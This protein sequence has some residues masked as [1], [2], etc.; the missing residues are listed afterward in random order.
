[1]LRG[2]LVNTNGKLDD[3]GPLLGR[4]VPHVWRKI[5]MNTTNL[6]QRREDAKIMKSL[7]LRTASFDAAY[8]IID[9]VDDR[10]HPSRTFIYAENPHGATKAESAERTE[11]LQLLCIKERPQKGERASRRSSNGRL[12]GW[13]PQAQPWS[14]IA[15]P[16]RDAQELIFFSKIQSNRQY[17]GSENI[18]EQS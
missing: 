15:D 18:A 6:I 7:V 8:K 13:Y 11:I 1:L 17:P 9:Y 12:A 14:E 10:Q 3:D 16:E 5:V 2:R 4:L